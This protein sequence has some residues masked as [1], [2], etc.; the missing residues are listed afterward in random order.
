MNIGIKNYFI[1]KTN[2]VSDTK[3]LQS[4][5]DYISETFLENTYSL[6]LNFQIDIKF[7]FKNSIS[8]RSV[9]Y[10]NLVKNLLPELVKNK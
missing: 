9:E 4:L 7:I 5:V 8:F 10:Y 2:V 3:L 1:D 6:L